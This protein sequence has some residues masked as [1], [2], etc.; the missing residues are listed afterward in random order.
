M[1]SALIIALGIA[2]ILYH[3]YMETD[4]WKTTKGMFE[5]VIGD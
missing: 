5:I 1:V 3:G 4:P 2:I